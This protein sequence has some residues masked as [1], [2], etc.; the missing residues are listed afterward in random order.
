M[1]MLDAPAPLLV[2]NP[3]LKE[4]KPAPSLTAEKSVTNRSLSS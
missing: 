1:Q 2:T 3:L 4:W